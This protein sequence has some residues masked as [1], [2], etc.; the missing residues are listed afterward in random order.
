MIKRNNI[1]NTPFKKQ[2]LWCF[3]LLFNAFTFAQQTLVKSFSSET[4]AIEIN[5]EGLDEIK[6][7]NSNNEQIEV[8][9]F[10]ENPNTHQILINEDASVLKIGF[11]LEFIPNEAIFRKFITKRINRASVIIKVPKNKNLT[12]L[13]T[14]I[15]V[16]SKNYNGNIAIYIDKG[17]VN[18]SEVQQSVVLKLFKGNIFASVFNTE[19][20]VNSRNGNILV[21]SEIHPKN[22]KKKTENSVKIFSVSSINANINLTVL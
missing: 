3:L 13:G 5:T 1:I 8:I 11:K 21:N 7:L 16:I 12:I 18:L 17:L 4:N 15:D 14:N 2:T 10:D 6:I 19:I 20:N 9:L 22:Y